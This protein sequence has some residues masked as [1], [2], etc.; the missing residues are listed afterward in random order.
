MRLSKTR[1]NKRT[2]RHK[3]QIGGNGSGYRIVGFTGRPMND[4]FTG[5]IATEFTGR[6]VG[7]IPI[8]LP[9]H[10]IPGSL[11]SRM[12]MNGTGGQFIILTELY[13]LE[14]VHGKINIYDMV[15]NEIRLCDKNEKDYFKLHGS[16]PPPINTTEL[17][18][19]LNEVQWS[20]QEVI[21]QGLD[22]NPTRKDI[23]IEI[24]TTYPGLFKPMF[25]N[26][27]TRYNYADGDNEKM[28]IKNIFDNV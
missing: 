15:R 19:W 7:T 20:P 13:K 23:I 10:E 16:T 21:Q 25:V 17:N 28:I 26:E 6:M 27:T 14:W 18:R 5:T 24:E 8:C 22:K 12:G 4:A 2:K 1:K 11:Y 3:K 9:D